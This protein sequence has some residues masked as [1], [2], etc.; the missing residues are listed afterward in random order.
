MICRPLGAFQ[1]RCVS[2]SYRHR[3]ERLV[4]R[5]RKHRCH[6]GRHSHKEGKRRHDDER[7][8]D[9]IPRHHDQKSEDDEQI[10]DPRRPSSSE[11]CSYSQ[12]RARALNCPL[13]G[14][15]QTTRSPGRPDARS[16]APTAR[17]RRGWWCVRKRRR[18]AMPL[19]RF[20]PGRLSQAGTPAHAGSCG[21]RLSVLSV[22]PSSRLRLAPNVLTW[23]TTECSIASQLYWPNK[24]S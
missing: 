2:S 1:R 14:G 12:A 7:E 6:A 21:H 18:C 4:Q 11:N 16:A 22:V 9:R 13:R 8:E 17:D 3:N 19:E 23:L 5:S 24:L 15:I 10:D 20:R